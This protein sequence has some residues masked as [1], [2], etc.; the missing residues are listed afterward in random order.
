MLK[1]NEEK[2]KKLAE[3]FNKTLAKMKAM[4]DEELY[5]YLD[6]EADVEVLRR[7]GISGSIDLLFFEIPFT[8]EELADFLNIDLDPEKH[9]TVGVKA[10]LNIQRLINKYE[11]LEHFLIEKKDEFYKSIEDYIEMK[12][13]D[14]GIN[15]KYDD[16]IKKLNSMEDE[17]FA[18]YICKGSLLESKLSGG[19]HGFIDGMEFEI[20]FDKNALSELSQD[21]RNKH[22]L[23]EKRRDL[24]QSLKNSKEEE[25]KL[26]LE[27]ETFF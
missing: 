24:I 7:N 9:R 1:R 21:E 20:A 16:L 22:F 18:D 23:I 27:S 2:F 17:E 10:T 26:Y 6:E 13:T 25:L 8:D 5:E 15:K 14:N 12:L 3:S 4:N 19:L 11:I